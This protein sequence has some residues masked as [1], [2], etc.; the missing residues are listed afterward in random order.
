MFPTLETRM[1]TMIRRGIDAAID[2]ATLGE[3]GLASALSPAGDDAWR[4]VP[5]TMPPVARTVSAAPPALPGAAAPGAV[6]PAPAA[7]LRPAS[8]A[9]RAARSTERRALPAC[10]GQPTR[11]F[12][13][14]HPRPPQAKRSRKG[15]V[16]APAQLCLL[17]D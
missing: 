5:P 14:G 2:F 8:A 1:P 6:A 10:A 11:T 12:S 17:A 16:P 3:Y 4:F 9:A 7:Q 13:A 15:T